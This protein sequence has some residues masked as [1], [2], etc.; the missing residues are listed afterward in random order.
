MEDC[1]SIRDY[2]PYLLCRAI[3]HRVR[4]RQVL[5]GEEHPHASV[6]IDPDRDRCPRADYVERRR[7]P[8]P[9]LGLCF[10]RAHDGELCQIR[11]RNCDDS[12]R[13]SNC[14]C[15]LQNLKLRRRKLN[16]IDI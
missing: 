1:P 8:G 15:V 10:L 2:I 9:F 5:P 13:T 4:L 7:P 11:F 12:P 14:R 16:Q 3:R 6:P